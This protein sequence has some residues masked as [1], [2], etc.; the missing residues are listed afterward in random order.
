MFLYVRQEG[1]RL[2]ILCKWM[3]LL[4][5]FVFS[6]KDKQRTFDIRMLKLYK[7]IFWTTFVGKSVIGHSLNT[8]SFLVT[9]VLMTHQRI[10][11]SV[12][13]YNMLT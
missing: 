2:A 5:I 8:N 1:V 13:L 10:L 3:G 9:A 4:K 7:L 12:C 6:V 11:F